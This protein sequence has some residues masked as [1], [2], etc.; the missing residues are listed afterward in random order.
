[1]LYL[2]WLWFFLGVEDFLMKEMV[3]L[4]VVV[5]LFC[6]L[7][8]LC[9]GVVGKWFILIWELCLRVVYIRIVE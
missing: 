4:Y 7:L 6:W 2:G 1:M 5:N 3:F 9:L 8:V